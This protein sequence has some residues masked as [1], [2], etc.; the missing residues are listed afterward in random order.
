M[1]RLIVLFLL[2]ASTASAATITV[3]TVWVDGD[4][5]TAVKLNNINST[6]ANVINGGLDNTNAN[7]A[8]GYF[9]FKRVGSLPA[10]G[11]QGAVYFQTSDNTLNL[12]TGS[13]FVAAATIGG[14]HAKGD[15]IIY[16]GSAFTGLA[17]GTSGYFL[18]TLGA[19]S[20][21]VWA[22]TPQGDMLYADS[23]VKVG[24][25]TRVMNAG[26]GDVSYTGVGFTP[27]AIMF[28]G[29]VTNDTIGQYNGYDNGSVH[30]SLSN[31]STSGTGYN[32]YLS[33]SSISLF[34]TSGNFQKAIVKSFDADGFTLTW[35]LGGAGSADTASIA[36]IAFR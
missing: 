3:P 27:K 2:I 4:S 31:F 22:A 1:K 25:F 14:S 30:Y 12:D 11:T 7:T 33:D 17:A 15:V 23:R 24:A 6:F 20:N 36:Y 32:S 10:A 9:F 26:S 13:S 35:T 19:G 21:P 5:V 34:R 18:K 16:D 8:S 28:F 29:G